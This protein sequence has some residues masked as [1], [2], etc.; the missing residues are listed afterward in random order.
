MRKTKEEP[1]NNHYDDDYLRLINSIK[2]QQ[3]PN[4][5]HVK[6]ADIFSDEKTKIK[7]ELI[8]ETQI[9]DS[10]LHIVKMWKKPINKPHS[11]KMDI[12]GNKGLFAYFR[13]FKSIIIDDKIGTIKIMI[14]IHKIWII[15]ICL[16]LTV[17]LRAF[18]ENHCI[19]LVGHTGLEKTKRNILEK[20][21]FSNINTW[22]KILI[23]DCLQCQTNNM[24]ANTEIKS[25]QEQFATTK[26]YFNEMIMI[27]TKGP[28]NPT[29]EGY[30]YVFVMVDAFSHYVTIKCAPKNNAHYAFT[31]LFERW[32]MKFGLP[33]EI[34]LDYGSEYIKTELT[35][36]CDYFEIKF[37]PKSTYAPWTN[38]LVEGTN[39]IIGQFIRT[40]LNEKYNNWARKA[41]FLPYAY[42]T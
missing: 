7:E 30:N 26:T 14:N 28:I 19:D 4:Y 20:Y 31:A 10:I 2:V 12:R 17:L 24:F 15:G 23:A 38:G 5:E 6:I 35:H 33:E 29:S 9:F 34:R 8:K 11:V 13:K 37:K 40:L 32:F 39:R 18:H 1:Y 21:Y 36:L 22:I 41:K 42:S 27:D 3:K 16:P 25:K